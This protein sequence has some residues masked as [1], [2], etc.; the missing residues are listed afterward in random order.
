METQ[1]PHQSGGE[2]QGHHELIFGSLYAHGRGV[3][4]PCDATGNV[5]IDALTQRMR[6]TYLGA[7]AMIGREYAY[8]TVHV[9]H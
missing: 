1:M 5:D 7:R 3:V 8:P 9:A 4:V 6:D 2:P